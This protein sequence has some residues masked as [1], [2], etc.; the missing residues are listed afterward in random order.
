MYGLMIQMFISKQPVLMDNQNNVGVALTKV[1]TEQF[2]ILEHNFD[3]DAE[4]KLHV[5][6]RFLADNE[7]HKIAVFNT[8]YFETNA[9]HFLTIEA[10][11]HFTISPDS[12]QH[13]YHPPT[14]TLTV[15][16]VVLHHL[17]MLTVGTCRGILHAKTENTRFNQYHIPTINV[18][19]LI[20]EDSV[21]DFTNR[22]EI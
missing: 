14:N 22:S 6:F 12:W 8:I 11:C 7:L 13:I 2:A 9:K 10:G 18:S 4:I 17:A 20:T 21:F 5:N 3:A 16:K 15:P 19:E 1:T